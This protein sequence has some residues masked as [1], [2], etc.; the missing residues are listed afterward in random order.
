MKNM[1]SILPLFVLAFA[2]MLNACSDDSTTGSDTQDPSITEIAALNAQFSTLV[3]ALQATGLDAALD[4]DGEF[5][6]FAPTND[7]FAALP[8]GTLESLTEE[9]LESILLYHVLGAEVFSGQLNAQQTV[10]TLN[11][12]EIFITAGSGG[13]SVNGTASV[14]SADIEAR[15]GVI[16]V[17]DGVILPDA[18]GTIVDNAIKRYFLSALVDAVIQADLV[19]ALLGEGPFTVFAPTNEA[20]AAIADVASGLTVEELTDVLLYH[21]IQGE[22]LSSDLQPS[23]Q[24]T[25][26]NGESLTIEVSGGSAT[27]NGS[28]GITIV[29]IQGTNGVIHVIDQV[30]LPPSE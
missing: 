1:K 20:F 3:G 10:G 25:T 28:S 13:V 15:N 12:E 22:V 6:V 2:L 7:A 21:V 29:D 26:L 17:I 14:T 27:V 24:V 5:T 11:G 18:Y 9:Q 19:D 4:G 8:S 23:Q 30:L 16:H